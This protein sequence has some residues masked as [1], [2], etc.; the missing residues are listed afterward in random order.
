MNQRKDFFQ[1][2]A[3]QFKKRNNPTDLKPAIIGIVTGLN[4]LCVSIEDGLINL[5]ENDNLILSE[6]FKIRTEI[7]KESDL[8][9]QVP[10][11]LEQAEA[12]KETHSQGGA[13]CIM[14]DAVALVCQAIRLINAELLKHKIEL[15]Q[16]DYVILNSAEQEDTY[17]LI[18]KLYKGA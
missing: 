14:P 10:N 8:S 12:I 17:I 13:P 18:D 2:M 6:W 7:D 1:E 15:Q 11:L 5:F 16:G 3:E 9:E 4:P